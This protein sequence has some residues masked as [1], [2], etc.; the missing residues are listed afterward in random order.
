MRGLYARFGWRRTNFRGELVP[1]RLGLFPLF[2]GLAAYTCFAE[3]Q[4]HWLLT[5]GYGVLGFV[6]DQW[7]QHAPKG[8]RGHLRSL[9]A[10]R[11]TTGLLK[12]VGGLVLGIAIG[13]LLH[14]VPPHHSPFAIHHSLLSGLMIALWANFFNLLDV[15]PGRAGVIFMLLAL[16]CVFALFLRG[17]A[18][19]ALVLSGVLLGLLV[20]LPLDRAGKGM[21][22]DTGSNLLGG[23]LGV[24]LAL[25]MPLWAQGLLTLGLLLLHFWA[26]RHSLT[27]W[28][29][30]HP[31]LR[32]LDRLTG[33]R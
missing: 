18:P 2:L 10:G 7:G 16:P 28:I 12:L 11:P 8:L 31:T 23:V 22:G 21:L 19:G 24:S 3:P 14:H 29:E 6:D 15:R 9:L 20:V 33:V 30:R 13:V 26:E 5:L 25:L 27:D 4:L 17:D 32:R 1:D